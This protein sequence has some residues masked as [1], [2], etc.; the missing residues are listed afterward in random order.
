M[1]VGLR[2]RIVGQHVSDERWACLCFVAGLVQASGLQRA[3]QLGI[4]R[5]FFSAAGDLG[6]SIYLDALSVTNGTLISTSPASHQSISIE[7]SIVAFRGQMLTWATA[8]YRGS[9][10]QSLTRQA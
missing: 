6:Y 3:M 4:F 7:K 8:R 9:F 10:K 1:V 5:G 2:V